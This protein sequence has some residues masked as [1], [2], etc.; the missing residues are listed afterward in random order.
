MVKVLYILKLFLVINDAKVWGR[1]ICAEGPCAGDEL[2]VN[3]DNS[4]LPVVVNVTTLS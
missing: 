3:V 4:T 2:T 1:G